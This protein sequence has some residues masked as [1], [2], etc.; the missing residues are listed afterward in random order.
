MSGTTTTATDRKNELLQKAQAIADRAL[1]DG[2]RPFTDEERVE[3]KGY[4]DGATKIVEQ[5]K[6]AKSDRDLV[7]AMKALGGVDPGEPISETDAKALNDQSLGGARVGIDVDS[8]S[9][10]DKFVESESYKSF[11]ARHPNGAGRDTRIALDPLHVAGAKA[12]LGPV[13]MPGMVPVDARGPQGPFVWGRQL[14]LR[15][16]ITSGSTTSDVV[17]F[18]RQLAMTNAAAP[19][20]TTLVDADDAT[21]TT[22]EGFKPQSIFTFEKV[23]QN[24]KTIAHWLAATK[25]SLSDVGQLRTLI[26]SFLRFGL[27]EELEDQ[28]ISGDGTGENFPGIT[29]TSGVQ[30]Q[31][32]SVNSIE[33]IRK[34]I[35][36]VSLVG[37]ARPTAVA[38]HPSDD[39]ALDLAKDTQNRYYGNG[40]FG[41][42]PSTIWGLPRV[43]TEAVPV[44][45]AYVADWRFAALW[46]REDAVI[47]ATDSHKDF[48][49]RNLIAVLAELRAAFGIIRPAAFVIADLTA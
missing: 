1:N 16:V 7:G 48:F 9:L 12:L 5:V 44:G 39:E 2:D 45:W 41:T 17:E 26:D 46:D 27:E 3:I 42:G 10:G 14:M 21:P 6:A 49:V 30:A 33:T 8:K 29:T 13:Q 36:K 4:I 22:A 38:I 19:V 20:P 23:T 43:V 28:I 35:T 11:V 34:A 18:A 40:P 24:V 37:R 31:A 32:F 15:D 47:T 25:R